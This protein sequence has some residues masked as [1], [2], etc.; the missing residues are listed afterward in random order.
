MNVNS[1]IYDVIIVGAGPAG[2]SAAIT[3]SELK[4]RVLIID[5]ETFPRDKVCGDGLTEES[6]EVVK[7]LGCLD[8]IVKEG[9]NTSRVVVNPFKD[10][11]CSVH[12]NVIT[13]KRYIFDNILLQHAIK[14]SASFQQGKFT[15]KYILNNDDVTIEIQKPGSNV[16]K[17]LRA[18]Y[19]ILSIGA[20]N[21]SSL[22]NCNGIKLKKS[23]TIG[24]RG[25]YKADWPIK[26]LNI[27]YLE[28]M[29]KTAIYVFP[30]GNNLFNIGC[31]RKIGGK[32]LDIK[33]F[34]NEFVEKELN[35]KYKVNG[36]W[37]EPLKGAFLR[38][39]LSSVGNSV[40]GRVILTGEACGTTN[41]FSG[42]GIAN[43]LKSGTIAGKVIANCLESGNPE[44]IVLYK[45]RLK[46]VIKK[47]Q[48][49]YMLA[50]KI[51]V[52]RVIRNWFYSN[53]CKLQEAK[54]R[55]SVGN[56][57][58]KKRIMFYFMKKMQ[59]VFMKR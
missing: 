17:Q 37:I 38:T 3:L 48:W 43:A 50:E 21:D 57:Y 8:D 10:R 36:A 18:K 2:L 35:K 27:F 22:K 47:I 12:F 11:Y 45:K 53:I 15:G 14:C 20:Q 46:K 41:P 39:G 23:T 52:K 29:L 1:D 55:N 59:N 24:V 7:E 58:K 5:Q 32:K 30:L 54:D 9:F 6:I 34:I 16:K 4:H 40:D 44:K 51:L 31:C 33:N 13:I 25:Y 49:P 28:K 26:E 42:E 19:V 56:V